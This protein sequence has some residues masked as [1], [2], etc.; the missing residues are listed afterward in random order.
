LYKYDC[1]R[2]LYYLM[3]HEWFTLHIWCD[4]IQELN[5]SEFKGKQKWI[6]ANWRESKSEF[7]QI[8]GKAKVNSNVPNMNA[9]R[10]TICISANSSKFKQIQ[11]KAKANSNVPN[12]N[13]NTDTICKNEKNQKRFWDSGIFGF[14][15]FYNVFFVVFI[16]EPCHACN[17]PFCF[18]NN[19]TVFCEHKNNKKYF[20]DLGVLGF[21]LFYNVFLDVFIVQPCN[22]CNIAFCFCEHKN[23]KNRF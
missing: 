17:I 10:D 11:G 12:I 15:L 18:P 20:W 5:S 3:D 14:T 13:G 1:T 6:Q 21:P 8:Q 23:N 2:T 22:A 9:N 16:V 4:S 19:N 7:K